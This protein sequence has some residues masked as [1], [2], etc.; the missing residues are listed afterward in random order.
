MMHREQCPRCKELGK[1]R[2]QDNLAIYDDGH[3]FCYAC[4]YHVPASIETKITKLLT[5]IPAKEPSFLQLPFDATVNL[6]DEIYSRL[7][8]WGIREKDIKR[9]QFQ[10]SET[11]KALIMPVYNQIGQLVMYQERTWDI[12]QRKYSTFGNKSDIIHIIRPADKPEKNYSIIIVE[13]LIS[14]IRVSQY[15]N[16]MPIWGSD[17]PL[18]TILRL[19]SLFTMTGVWLD[20][21]M[22]LKAV[23][24]VLRISQYM[25]CFFVE[26]HLD[27]KFY[28]LDR[29][30][31]HIDISAYSMLY[32][33][34]PLY[35]T[36]R[37]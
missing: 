27:P 3:R 34:K 18:K 15:M 29:I 21:D 17:I 1:D 25:P 10:W 11:R 6:P 19:A 14:A 36:E 20:P 12:G 5:V 35:S 33:D 30:K 37:K 16:A 7:S 26:S 8:S 2:S 22:K 9:H 4:G 32:K 24:D 13:D 28:N 23:K 31:E